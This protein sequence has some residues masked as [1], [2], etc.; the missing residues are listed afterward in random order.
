[1]T[2]KMGDC[3]DNDLAITHIGQE[4][5]GWGRNRTK[6]LWHVRD[7]EVLGSNP[8]AV[9]VRAAAECRVRKGRGQR[10]DFPSHTT[11][12]AYPIQP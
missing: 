8:E 9:A 12:N 2:R 5:Y 4:R 7:A 3:P 1:M 11:L 10:P 6:K